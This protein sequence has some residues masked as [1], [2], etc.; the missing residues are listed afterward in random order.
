MMGEFDP[1]V[2]VMALHPDPVQLMGMAM[3]VTTVRSK[4]A[5]RAL[6]ARS[7]PRKV[8]IYMD[9]PH[10]V[11]RTRSKDK[12][13]AKRSAAQ[14][15]SPPPGPPP[16]GLTAANT[17]TARRRGAAKVAARPKVSA[18]PAPP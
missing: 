16:P 7:I 14:A 2:L 13:Q 6:M 4:R 5:L 15:A 9:G 10:F 17:L 18:H 3:Y 11:L 8:Q 1:R 12:R